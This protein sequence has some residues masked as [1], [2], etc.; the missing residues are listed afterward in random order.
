LL[1]GFAQHF[2]RDGKWSRALRLYRLILRRRPHTTV[3]LDAILDPRGGP[4]GL[5][6]ALAESSD[7]VGYL[8]KPERR[9]EFAALVAGVRNG[10][11]TESALR[12]GYGSNVSLLERKWGS[13][14]GRRATLATIYVCVGFPAILLLGVAIGRALRR[15]R[16]RLGRRWFG[17]ARPAISSERPRVHIV[18]SRR[19]ER[20][21]P[22]LLPEAEIPKVEHEGEW[23]TLH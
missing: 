1:E 18:F 23:H 15:R 4:E 19:D 13:D 20:I 21:D 22:P 11:A 9:A 8:Q 14:L 17:K 3:E 12:T 7:F 5:E 16:A 6:I 2:S 10:E